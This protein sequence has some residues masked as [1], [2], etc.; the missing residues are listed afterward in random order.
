MRA[1]A[2]VWRWRR[3]PLRRATDRAEAW[4][5]LVAA[6]LLV[7]AA[8]LIGWI[9]G[10]AADESLERQA[11]AQRQQRQQVTATVLGPA[12]AAPA[13]AY[14]PDTS[15]VTGKHPLVIAEWTAADGGKRTG[16][17][18]SR[19]REPRVG[20]SFGVWT[21]RQGRVVG[22]PMNATAVRV[23]TVLAGVAAALASAV[24]VES[25]RRLVLWRLV[26][27]RHERLDRAWA[28]VGPDWGR[29]GAGS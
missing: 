25:V 20:D 28:T 15:A 17:L 7:T 10:A 27:R 19:L 12:P 8:P 26:R 6:L 2:G 24:L 5:T 18:A 3:N 16:R 14:L 29:A 9:S 1:A 4:M 13:G 21:D 11:R 23:N 22:R